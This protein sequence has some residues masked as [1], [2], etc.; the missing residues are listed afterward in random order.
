MSAEHIPGCN[1]AFRKEAFQIA[2]NLMHTRCGRRCD[3]AG[4]TTPDRKI[5]YTER[6]SGTAAYGARLPAAEG[7]R[8]AEAH[9]QKRYPGRFN[10]FGI[11]LER[12]VT[13]ASIHLRQQ[14]LP[15]FAR[16]AVSRFF[17][18]A[19]FHPYQPF[20]TCGSIF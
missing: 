2:G 18:A 10:F 15:V 19:Q 12:G 3:F 9:L 8:A 11:R 16:V 6:L 5:V 14:G 4:V 17:C 20:L 7:L 13:T 1:M